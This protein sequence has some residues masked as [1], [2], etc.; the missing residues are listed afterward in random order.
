MR[1]PLKEVAFRLMDQA[2][3]LT[4]V[5]HM[6]RKW[7]RLLMYHRFSR[8]PKWRCMD[9]AVFEQQIAYLRRHFPIVDLDAIANHL[10]DEQPLPDRA[11]AI[12]VDDAFEDFF[13]L[14]LP[15]LKKYGVPATLYVPTDFVDGERS[16]WPDRLHALLLRTTESSVMVPTPEDRCRPVCARL[17]RG[18]ANGLGGSC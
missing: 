17:A 11:V 3:G 16:L 10:A 4:V 6:T 8:G 13:T 12:T 15:V 1:G 14:A 5:G 7:P 2:G 9:V 18:K